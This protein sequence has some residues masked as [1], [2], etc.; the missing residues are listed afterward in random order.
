[1]YCSGSVHKVQY[2]KAIFLIRYVTF[3][4]LSNLFVASFLVLTTN[5]SNKGTTKSEMRCLT[6]VLLIAAACCV[7]VIADDLCSSTSWV[8]EEYHLEFYDPNRPNR[9]AI[10]STL[11]YPKGGENCSFPAVFFGHSYML[12]AG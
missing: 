4:L 5:T 10:R 7:L 1:M 11:Y 12:S 6:S 3:L 9:G 2:Q 8:P